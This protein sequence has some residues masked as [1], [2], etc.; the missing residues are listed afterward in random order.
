MG[1]ELRAFFARR[2]TSVQNN[3]PFNIP[4]LEGARWN[5]ATGHV[6]SAAPDP[7][8]TH[9]ESCPPRQCRA[10]S[11]CPR[12]ALP[13]EGSMPLLQSRSSR[14]RRPAPLRD[15]DSASTSIRPSQG[16][17][18]GPQRPCDSINSAAPIA[19][20]SARTFPHFFGYHP[21]HGIEECSGA[22]E[23]GGASKPTE[24]GHFQAG[25]VP[26]PQSFPQK[27]WSVC[28]VAKPR[29]GARLAA[30]KAA[31]RLTACAPGTAPSGR[32]LLTW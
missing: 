32:S 24:V 3:R 16:K 12:C 28:T 18:L 22:S 25:D 4:A 20:R 13:Q 23:T 14:T 6:S 15:R 8:E 29:L 17:P 19:K 11:C 2:A 1:L 9:Q 26:C 7:Y 10:V 30:G 5:A 27:L 31:P 21:E